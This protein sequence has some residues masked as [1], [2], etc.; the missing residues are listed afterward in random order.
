MVP[1]RTVEFGGGE[2]EQYLGG[3]KRITEASISFS[4][5]PFLACSTIEHLELRLFTAT[6]ISP[7]QHLAL[8]YAYL[9]VGSSGFLSVA[10]IFINYTNFF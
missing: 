3:R 9:P 10:F 2:R 7:H 1:L 5:F 8:A 6:E 4:R